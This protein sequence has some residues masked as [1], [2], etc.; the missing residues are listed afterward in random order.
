MPLAL[1]IAN[2][3]RVI[4]GALGLSATVGVLTVAALNLRAW[5]IFKDPRPLD[6]ALMCFGIAGVNC[7]LLFDLWKRYQLDAEASYRL[8]F[9]IPGFLMMSIGFWRF[10][11]HEGVNPKPYG[12]PSFLRPKK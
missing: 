3:F 4:A 8:Y 1:S 5:R 2:W 9:A 6:I 10:I 7:G 11:R 12:G